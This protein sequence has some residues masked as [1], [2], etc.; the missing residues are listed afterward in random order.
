M[1][2]L[3]GC[4]ACTCLKLKDG[5][6]RVYTFP[7]IVSALHTARFYLRPSI[8]RFQLLQA[9]M[10]ALAAVLAA[11][12]RVALAVHPPLVIDNLA[13]ALQMP[14][15]AVIASLGSND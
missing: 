15:A 11:L 9:A 4:V 2:R 5:S 1:F 3:S 8:E 13:S 7:C 12:E 14:R 10:T 6:D